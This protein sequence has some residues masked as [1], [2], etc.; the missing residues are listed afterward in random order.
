MLCF[1]IIVHLK[2]YSDWV[3]QRPT[4]EAPQSDRKFQFVPSKR[5]LWSEEK[6]TVKFLNPGNS[7][8]VRNSDHSY[9]TKQGILD[10]ANEWYRVDKKVVPMFVLAEDRAPAD[11]RIKFIGEFDI[12]Q[13][14]SC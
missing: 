13:V 3:H 12:E 14:R 6:I 8:Q 10:I 9:I 5:H 2:C 1:S 11:I 7:P 4:R